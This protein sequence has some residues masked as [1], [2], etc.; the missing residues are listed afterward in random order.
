[1]PRRSAVSLTT[2]RVPPRVDGRPGRL[3]APTWLAAAEAEVFRSIVAAVDP[4]HFT[5]SD[6]VLLTTYAESIVLARRAA[7]ELRAGLVVNGKTNPW[8][9]AREKAVREMV[10]LSARL[11]LSPQ[12]RSGGD[13]KTVAR[14]AHGAGA[15]ASPYDLFEAEAEDRCPARP[16]TLSSVSC[17]RAAGSASAR[18]KFT[19]PL[20]PMALRP[21]RQVVLG[22]PPG[23]WRN[24]SAAGCSPPGALRSS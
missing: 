1:M 22:T 2:P 21:G 23:R 24:G 4:K 13:P 11:R 19:R 5:P 8:L 7:Q 15:S 6:M 10:A 17:V 20:S 12:S 14:R 16:K 3:A 9:L 18:G